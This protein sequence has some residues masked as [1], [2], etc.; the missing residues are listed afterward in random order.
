MLYNITTALKSVGIDDIDVIYPDLQGLQ[1]SYDTDKERFILAGKEGFTTP[2]FSLDKDFDKH[3]LMPVP[4]KSHPKD[5]KGSM[6]H[7]TSFDPLEDYE[8]IKNILS[9]YVNSD[10]VE[11]EPL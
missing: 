3:G 6:I 5:V 10:M 7:I 2:S 4:T 8:L 9:K 11:Y 1:V